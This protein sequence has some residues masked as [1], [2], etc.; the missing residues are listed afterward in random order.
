MAIL[1]PVICRLVD[2]LPISTHYVVASGENFYDPGYR[3]G[4]VAEGG[5]VRFGPDYNHN[6]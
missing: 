5:K 2:N 6:K 4:W 1:Q 3:L